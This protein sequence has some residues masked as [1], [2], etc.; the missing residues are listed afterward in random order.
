VID[1]LMAPSSSPGHR[2]SCLSHSKQARRSKIGTGERNCE[3]HGR[4]L[5]CLRRARGTTPSRLRVLVPESQFMPAS[6]HCAREQ[7]ST[8]RQRVTEARRYE[9]V[10]LG[11][12]TCHVGISSCGSVS[13][14][15][16]C[17]LWHRHIRSTVDEN[18]SDC[19][20]RVKS[21]LWI[22]LLRA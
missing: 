16:A 12:K 8:W 18:A 22:L 10:S 3:L 1:E 4:G 6:T 7:G 14:V 5:A 13:L 21:G 11:Q 19:A 15:R 20:A 9:C 2:W 17:M